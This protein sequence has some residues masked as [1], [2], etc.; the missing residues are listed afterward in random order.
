[1]IMIMI[2][3]LTITVIMVM[4]TVKIT[5]ITQIIMAIIL[6][7]RMTIKIRSLISLQ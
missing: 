1:M 5:T 6:I 3:I 2:L 4:I 7:S